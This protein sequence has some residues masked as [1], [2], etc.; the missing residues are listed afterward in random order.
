MTAT[1]ATYRACYWISDDRQA[2]LVLTGPEHAHLSD[3]ELIA[4]ATAEAERAG[5][6]LDGGELKIGEWRD[7]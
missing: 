6:S 3:A 4:E 2:D 7:R 1:A 5:I